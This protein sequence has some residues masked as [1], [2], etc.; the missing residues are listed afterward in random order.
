MISA[1]PVAPSVLMDQVW[2]PLSS[3][4][5]FTLVTFMQRLIKYYPTVLHGDNR[6]TQVS[7]WMR[8]HRI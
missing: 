8:L 1:L 7:E 5:T 3:S 4:Q 2:D 6:N